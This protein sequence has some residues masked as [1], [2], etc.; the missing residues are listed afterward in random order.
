MKV[1]VILGRKCGDIHG[2]HRA[3]AVFTD[4]EKAKKFHSDNEKKIRGLEHL[5][6]S[7][8]YMIH[9]CDLDPTE[10]EEA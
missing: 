7:N 1:H 6:L 8:Y 4:F 3:I 10:M 5:R 9:T 2:D